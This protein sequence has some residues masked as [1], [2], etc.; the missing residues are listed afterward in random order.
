MKV[1]EAARILGVDS[2]TV[3][4]W[5]S[6]PLLTAFFSL[7]ARNEH[8]GSQRVLTEPDILVLNTIRARRAQG[9]E[10]ETIAAYLDSG[11]REKDFPANAISVDTRVI[12][13]P[14]AEQS[15]RAMALLAERDAALK[16]VEELTGRIEQ[17]EQ[18][19]EE[20]REKLTKE[21]KQLLRELGRLEGL[22]E[23]RNQENKE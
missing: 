6:H 22:L 18:E 14:Q 17:L 1:G 15:A 4:N 2:S 20:I 10:W 13:V 19:K 23:A 8:G 3:R 11:E 12:S 16:R 21:I 7:S 5:I 9:E